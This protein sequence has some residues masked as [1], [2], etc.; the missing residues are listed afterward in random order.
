MTIYGLDFTSCPTKRKPITCASGLLD[1]GVLVVKAVEVF[2]SFSEFEAFLA[3]PG[4]WRAGFDFPFGQPR[5]LLTNLGLTD[6]WA[7]VVAWFT[8]RSRDDF[9]ELL[10][11]YRLKRAKGDKQHRR[12]TD[13]LAKSCSPMMLYGTP[14]A[15][16]FFEGAPRL[17]RSAISIL[18]V[19]PCADNRVAVE[20]YPKLVAA[21]YSGRRKYKADDKASQG[22]EQ[23]DTRETILRGLVT[24]AHA[25]YGFEVR[26]SK[27]LFQRAVADPTGD[28]LDAVL[29]AVQGAWSAGKRE[30]PDGIPQDCDPVE[31]WIVDPSLLELVGETENLG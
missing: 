28:V 9:V 31:G 26:V 25:D 10:F 27:P 3:R 13:V 6:S 23:R 24:H 14:V 5:Q 22:T 20:A 17:L 19:R 29:A 16:M 7:E 15:K 8:D 18:P 11:H 21:R 1:H 2:S 30:P 4:P 12:Q